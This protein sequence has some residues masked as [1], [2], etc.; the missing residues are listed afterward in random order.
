MPPAEPLP[1]VS[2]WRPGRLVDVHL[3]LATLRRGAGDPAYR[4]EPDGTVWRACRTPIG[5]ATLRLSSRPLAGEVLITAWG[6]GAA[7]AVDSLPSL[8]GRFD[9]PTG[10]EPAHPRLQQAMLRTAGWRVP[11]SGL[12]L[13]ALVAAAIEQKVTGQ[14]A[15]AGWRILLRR[16]GETAPGP[17]GALGMRVLPSA[18]QWA[19]IPSWEWLRAG[20]DGKR[21]GTAIRAARSAGRL[22]QTVG[23]AHAD[24]ERLLTSVAGVGI[25]TAAEV[26]QRAHG[27]ADAVS[28]G[29]YHVAKNIGWALTG[30]V[31]DDD[32]LAELL[33]PYR[34]H[35]Y[36]VQRLLE[37]D[38]ARRPRHGPRMGPRTHLPGKAVAAQGITGRR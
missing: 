18:Q 15:F 33:E 1:L 34:P 9:D 38:G 12:V 11:R 14:E 20:V 5:P 29:D 28:F 32:G 19:L 26:R 36:R 10:F 6:P 25:W 4:L 27:D 3:T 7:W 13:E 16:F 24:A 35:R 8:L 22:E 37:L 31:V 30:S 23:L 21:S 17:A 2:A